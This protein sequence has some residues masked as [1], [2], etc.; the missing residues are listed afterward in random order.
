MG[1]AKQTAGNLTGNTPLQVKGI[2]Q[3]MKGK[4]ENAFGRAKDAVCG[5]NRK[6]KSQNGTRT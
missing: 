1:S 5:A 4:L 6:T 3:K 2:A